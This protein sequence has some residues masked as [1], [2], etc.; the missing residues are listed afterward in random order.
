MSSLSNHTPDPIH[1]RDI[2]IQD[3]RYDLPDE[4]IARF[5]LPER[6]AAKLLVYRQ[7]DIQESVFRELPD[8][9]PAGALLLFNDTRVI[10][11]RIR[12]QTQAGDPVE[13]FCLEPL[14]PGDYILNFSSP[15]PV[16]W[17]ALIG[18]NRKW[19][20]GSLSKTISTPSGDAVLTATRLGRYHD[21]FELEFAWNQPL[22]FAEVL[23]YAGI[24]PLPPYLKRD[25]TQEDTE[26][27]QTVYAR[28]DGS[29]AAPTAGLHFTERVFQR[30]EAQ[31]IE[32]QFATLH[33]GAGTFKPV[34]AGPVGAHHMHQEHICM[35][36]T[37]IEALRNALQD[38]RPI[39]PVGTTSMRI[40]ESL[41]WAAVAPATADPHAP[42][43][44]DVDQWMPYENHTTQPTPLEALDRLLERLH[45]KQQDALEG[46]TRILIAPGYRF[47]LS[48]G[49]ITNFHQPE[50]TL[51]LLIAALIGPDWRRIYDHALQNQFRFLSYGDSSL[52]L[53]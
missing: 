36:R 8:L 21:A 41:F 29:V 27:Y 18:N 25:S 17:K 51:L 5:P 19:K 4:R 46:N 26:R 37:T 53:P 30:M 47:H 22:V 24:I 10:Q 7:G 23:H 12:F 33:V 50:S 35:P 3:Y 16:R 42:L 49:L 1:P 52:L 32:V 43:I 11:A 2:H 39:I 34:Q 9:L 38:K 48:S 14:L 28:E 40:L 15:G 44:A 31:R 13:V 45:A 6:D 20:E